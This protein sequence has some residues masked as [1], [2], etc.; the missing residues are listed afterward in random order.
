MGEPYTSPYKGTG[1]LARGAIQS[2][3]KR[4]VL[5]ERRKTTK[6]RH[7]AGFKH[8]KTHP[9]RYRNRVKLLKEE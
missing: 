1:L 5:R 6:P 4:M 7:K 2:N 3:R 9:W 8:K